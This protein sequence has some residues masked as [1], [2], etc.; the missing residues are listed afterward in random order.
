[1]TRTTT[2]A[3]VLELYTLFVARIFKMQLK[4]QYQGPPAGPAAWQSTLPST[5]LYCCAN[6]CDDFR[7]QENIRTGGVP[8]EV[9]ATTSASSCSAVTY[10]SLHHIPLVTEV[11]C[12][13]F[14]WTNVLINKRQMYHTA[15]SSSIVHTFYVYPFVLL[16]GVPVL[17]SRIA[18][19]R[20][21]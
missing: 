10:P 17:Y 12:L 3:A 4:I 19:T 13:I 11:P 2:T 9:E 14:A 15:Y 7:L 18:L 5:T 1:M 6:T 8:Y 16:V 20:N 21:S